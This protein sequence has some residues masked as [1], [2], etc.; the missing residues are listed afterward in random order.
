[1]LVI[2]KEQMAAFRASLREQFIR[3]LMDRVRGRFAGQ[4]AAMAEP[5]IREWVE[6]G[7]TKAS[8]YG[9]SRKNEAQLFIDL[10]A[11]L[12]PR[13]RFEAVGCRHPQR[14]SS[15]QPRKISPR[16]CSRGLRTKR[17]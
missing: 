5:N 2:R 8:Q 16:G 6:M 9:Y 10:C 7:L 14:H 15:Q 1:M 12:R 3:G 17:S 11:E 13:F 4:F